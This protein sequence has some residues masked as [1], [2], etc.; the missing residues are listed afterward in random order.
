MQSDVKA[1]RALPRYFDSTG[2]FSTSLWEKEWVGHNTWEVW[3]GLG[4]ERYN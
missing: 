2:S 1:E 3:R 4:K